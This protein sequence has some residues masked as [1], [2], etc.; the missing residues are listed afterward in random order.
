MW[1][2]HLGTRDTGHGVHSER[3]GAG[4]AELLHD[5]LVGRGVEERDEGLALVHLGLLEGR[6]TD[7]EDNVA[8]GRGGGD[9]RAGSCVRR[10]GEVAS[11]SGTALDGDG[12]EAFLEQSLDT[13]GGYSDSLLASERLLRDADRELAIGDAG[14]LGIGRLDACGRV[15]A[16]SAGM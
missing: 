7:T 5:L 4:F 1:P 16:A 11:L 2:A 13:L 15:E 14:S 10:V 12:A 8:L 3:G 6:G 9:S